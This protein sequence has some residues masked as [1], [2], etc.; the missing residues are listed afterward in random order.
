[1]RPQLLNS[2]DVISA[3]LVRRGLRPVPAPVSSE[4][5]LRAEDL[6]GNPWAVVV[7]PE[8]TEDL[9]REL[10]RDARGRRLLVGCLSRAPSTALASARRLGIELLDAEALDRPDAQD[11]SGAEPPRPPGPVQ[12][13]TP[14]PAV[15][16][17]AGPRRT[18]L[19]PQAPTA[20]VPQP[21]LQVAVPAVALSPEELLARGDYEAALAGF[22][23]EA[24]RNPGRMEARLVI[25]DILHRLH[26]HEEELREYD[27]L[28]RLGVDGPK[29][30]LA[31]GAAL[32][33]LGRFREAVAVYDELLARLPEH[34][35]AW[36]NR[37]AAFLALGRKEP[38][39][40]S[41]ERALFFEPGLDE[42][43]QNLVLAGGTV[44]RM[45]DARSPWR[46]N[47][48]PPLSGWTE[49]A[50]LTSLGLGRESLVVWEA[51]ADPE[52]G[53][54]WLGLTAALQAYGQ[55]EAADR[56][57]EWAA[58]LG[59]AAARY[60]RHSAFVAEGRLPAAA[61]SLDGLDGPRVAV[62]RANLA[63]LRGESEEALRHL[64]AAATA[65]PDAELPW[66]AAGAVELQRGNYRNALEAFDR[67][68]AVNPGLAV[69]VSNRGVALWR[70]GR[71]REASEAFDSAVAM[72]P[73]D[74]ELWINLGVSRAHGGAEKLALRA[75]ETAARLAPEWPRPL[76]EIARLRRKRG[77]KRGAKRLLARAVLLGWRS[78]TGG[79]GSRSRRAARRASAGSRRRGSPR[80]A[81]PRAR[82][83][84]RRG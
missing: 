73:A 80:R 54:A 84:S 55:G 56:S 31:R 17:P 24:E 14:E 40:G 39:I 71:Y 10:F 4:G 65:D 15:P 70:M 35:L 68:L 9:V 28:G 75:F 79:T 53:N 23:H 46:S 16:P 66:N 29:I 57:L 49:A 3:L 41:L 34:A 63:R 43:R 11:P 13:P 18:A 78:P 1:V 74:P 21:I 82:D 5:F 6:H 81:G 36:N 27:A 83:A 38:A 47:P 22:R 12:P 32:H 62:A 50:A 76:V 77:D 7:L 37:G 2:E 67:A 45:K 33:R 44:R 25:A 51:H 72:A 69:A 20:P 30:R 42:A 8:V 52:D 26:R 19:T 58:S 59:N 60:A 64:T 61:E 48:V